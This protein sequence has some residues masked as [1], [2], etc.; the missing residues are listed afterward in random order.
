M[1]NKTTWTEKLHMKHDLPKVEKI[2]QRMGKHWGR[3]TIAIPAP[4]EVD[5]IMKKVGK[6]KIITINEIRKLI[7]QKHRATIGCPITCGIFAWIAA[8]AAD[9]QLGQGK[10]RITP[11]WRTL[12]SDGSLNEKYP[13][14]IKLQ[15]ALL[16]KEG[17]EILKEGKK[18]ILK[19]FEKKL[20]K[21]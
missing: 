21:I 19:D 15:R 6:G 17:H 3:G 9:E 18:Y 13:G 10:K 16:E 14:E 8:H 11:W 12:K 2:G 5:I 20:M 4:F 7:A 1:K